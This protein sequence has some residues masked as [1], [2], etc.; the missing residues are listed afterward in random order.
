MFAKIFT[1]LLLIAIVSATAVPE[2]K[3]E[4]PEVASP[5]VG[6][7]NFTKHPWGTYDFL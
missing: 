2:E 7:N 4:S 6:I 1:K 5:K 3:T